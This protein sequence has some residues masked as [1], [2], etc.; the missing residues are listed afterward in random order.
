MTELNDPFMREA[1]CLTCR[2]FLKGL[3]HDTCPECG[4]AFDHSDRRT[5]AMTPR[6]RIARIETC[7]SVAALIWLLGIVFVGEVVGNHYQTKSSLS[8]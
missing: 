2:Y 5:F 6:R 4:R 8:D 3:K 1:Y 7:V